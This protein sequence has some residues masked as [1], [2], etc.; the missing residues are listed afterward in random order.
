MTQTTIYRPQT[1]AL[2]ARRDIG[3]RLRSLRLR[4]GLTG[5]D[6]ADLLGCHPAKISRIEN[7]TAAANVA[8]VRKWC[9]NCSAEDEI[10]DL[11]AAVVA[12]D[13]AYAAWRS[14]QRSGLLRIQTLADGLYAKTSQVRAYESRVVPSLLQTEAYAETILSSLQARRGSP[15][16]AREAAAHRYGLRRFLHGDG[17]FAYIV[18]ESVLRS[19][20][21]PAE[22]MQRQLELLIEDSRLPRVSIGIVPLNSERAQWPTE[23]FYLY[24][25]DLLKVP[26]VS[27]RWT[28]TEPGDL[29]EYVT[30]FEALSASAVFGDEARDIISRAAAE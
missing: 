4:A 16:D 6:L 7:G 5:K 27:G 23:S 19:R 13:Q 30:V 17:T 14:E 8:D 9:V 22:V 3:I 20:I 25:A 18:E 15:D 24:D 28:A 1:N 21:A 12:A 2:A 26:L 10:S 11:T 29:S